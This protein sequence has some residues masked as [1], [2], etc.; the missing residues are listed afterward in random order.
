MIKKYVLRG[1]TNNGNNCYIISALQLL[2]AI[3]PLRSYI[4]HDYKVSDYT[5][6]SNMVPFFGFME[7]LKNHISNSS[8]LPGA[9]NYFKKL[10]GFS[11]N[12]YDTVDFLNLFFE[13]LQFDDIL[14]TDIK[15]KL[16]KYVSKEDSKENLKHNIKNHKYLASNTTSYNIVELQFNE[17]NSSEL[18]QDI[19]VN[20][21]ARFIYDNLRNG[22]NVTV[23]VIEYDNKKVYEV[24]DYFFNDY[25]IIR[26]QAF[27]QNHT[28]KFHKIL[29]CEN[30]SY[31]TK[32]NRSEY[33]LVAVICHL[34]KS[35]HSGHYICYV[36]YDGI[37][38]R[39]DDNSIERAQHNFLNTKYYHNELPY[40]VLYKLI[41]NNH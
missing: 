34:G 19:L 23:P 32:F 27:N 40:V 7:I 6:N 24:I 8:Q 28:K 3:E 5:N 18:I 41:K 22:H 16:Y 30:N 21:S 13:K 20:Q 14:S 38:Y 31:R 1:M 39:C 10:F 11:N 9:I 25:L 4:L 2:C 17:Q 33:E 26:I 35:I 37:W 12:Q 36:N 15:K 29:L